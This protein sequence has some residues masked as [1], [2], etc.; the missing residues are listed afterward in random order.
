[1]SRC[2]VPGWCSLSTSSRLRAAP[3]AWKRG[4]GGSE[5]TQAGQGRAGS[6]LKIMLEPRR[7]TPSGTTPVNFGTH[8]IEFSRRAVS[9]QPLGRRRLGR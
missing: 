3:G 2:R 1:M 9:R 5:Q 6:R 7:E 8:I 4:G